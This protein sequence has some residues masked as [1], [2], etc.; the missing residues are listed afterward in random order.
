MSNQ[1]TTITK[2]ILPLLALMF[3]QLVFAESK[4]VEITDG[5]PV[6]KAVDMLEA[7]YGLPIT[8][9]DTITVNEDQ[10]E[11]IT[12]KVQRTPDPSHR[13][14]GIKAKTISFAYKLPSSGASQKVSTNKTMA[15]TES[16]VADALSSVL[17]GYAAAGGFVTFSVTKE[18]G[19]FHVIAT[20]FLNK[21]GKMQ[22][23]TPLLDTK[24]TILP[25]QRTRIGL[26]HELCQALS[27]SSGTDVEVMDFPFNGGSIQAQTTTTISGTDVTAR[28]LLSQLIAE[29]SAPISLDTAIQI[30]NGEKR[31]WGRVVYKGGPVSWKLFYGTGADCVLHLR[32]IALENQ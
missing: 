18:D 5:Q 20:N 3:C 19:V 10:L 13:I 12:E 1:I 2:S 14:M 28:S 32:K 6:A 31:Q 7:I 22:P 23:L 26:F 27:E 16:E 8:Y 4:T 15:E 24:I 29:L 21:E 17:D 11:D 25:K 30:P 9:E